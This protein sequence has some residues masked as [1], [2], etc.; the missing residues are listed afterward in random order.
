MRPAA[1]LFPTGSSDSP[2]RRRIGGLEHRERRQRGPGDVG[3]SV[4]PRV[5]AVSWDVFHGIF[6][7]F[8]GIFHEFKGDSMIKSIHVFHGMIFPWDVYNGM[9][10]QTIDILVWDFLCPYPH[11]WKPAYTVRKSNM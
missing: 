8:D 6:T 2:L 11:L 4:A 7:E 3:S 10:S 5:A 9:M 1:Q